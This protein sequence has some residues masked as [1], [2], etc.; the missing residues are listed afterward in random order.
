MTVPLKRPATADPARPDTESESK[1]SPPK[2]LKPPRK[3]AVPGRKPGRPRKAPP[4][5][6]ADLPVEIVGRIA[7]FLLPPLVTAQNGFLPPGTMPYSGPRL[8][9]PTAKVK[10]S[11][12]GGIPS[13]I[14]D[15]MALALSCRHCDAGVELVMGRMGDGKSK[16]KKR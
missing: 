1:P 16:G 6:L 4:L 12:Y 15:I 7:S 8:K 11:A 13:G 9:S 2:R 14:K 3:K 5:G 10:T